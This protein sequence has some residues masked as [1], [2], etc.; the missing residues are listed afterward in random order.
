[1]KLLVALI[2]FLVGIVQADACGDVMWIEYIPGTVEERLDDGTIVFN[3]IWGVIHLPRD[4]E[5]FSIRIWEESSGETKRHYVWENTGEPVYPGDSYP[6][7][8]IGTQFWLWTMPPE[9]YYQI[10][11][12]AYIGL[13][14]W[15]IQHRFKVT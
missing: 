2:L 5:G 11:F 13:R 7:V 9:I 3:E 1:M 4:A 14:I 10:R 12:E 6:T 15:S 8:L